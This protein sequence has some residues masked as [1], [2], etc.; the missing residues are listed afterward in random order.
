MAGLVARVA[1][2]AAE[3]FEVQSDGWWMWVSG[4][5][6]TTGDAI[7]RICANTWG[8]SSGGQVPQ[9]ERTVVASPGRF[10][11]KQIESRF[12]KLG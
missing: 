10:R 4:V 12:T 6:R 9:V 11:E 5:L 7:E 1:S 3:F 8:V 2:D